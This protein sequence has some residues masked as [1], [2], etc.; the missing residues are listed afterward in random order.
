MY[1]FPGYTVYCEKEN[2]LNVSSKLFR[3]EVK[4][5]EPELK[6]EFYSLVKNG[7]CTDIS[8][9]LT[10]FLHEQDLLVNETEIKTA[11]ENAKSLLRNS[12]LLTIMPTENCNFRCPYCYETHNSSIMSP[13]T[14]YWIHD[15]IKKQIP[16]FEKLCISWF[17][18]EPTL[19][20]NIILE[21]SKLIQ[22]LQKE[23]HFI[24]NAGMTTNGYLLDK[25][26]FI[27]YYNLGITGYQITLDG[28]NHDKT[29]P[30]ISGKGTLKQIVDN[31]LEIS[32]LPQDKY[33]FNIV[34]RHNILANDNDYSWYDYL[35]RLFGKDKRFSIKIALVKDWGG[36]SVKNLNLSQSKQGESLKKLHES[37]L[38]KIGLQREKQNNTPFCNIC[39]ASCPYGFIFRSNGKVEKCTIAIDNPN[40]QVGYIDPQ[41]GVIID[42]QSSDKWCH[43]EINQKCYTCSD[44]LSCLNIFCRKKIIIDGYPDKDCLCSIT[45]Q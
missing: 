13:Q 31:L 14:L 4:I 36:D 40:N 11:L 45:E 8:T 37:Y 7:G 3:N 34:I 15:Y 44:V 9:P 27:L 35:N 2:S 18:G 28:W 23:Y 6:E 39:Y 16:K 20:K 26:T 30:H 12:L 38:D 29:R 32:S 33:Q 1:I 41:K 42:K 17:G 21:T 43:S 25:E 22:S 10:K 19:C 24:Y 5:T